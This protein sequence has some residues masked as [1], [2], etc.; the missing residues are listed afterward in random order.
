MILLSTFGCSNSQTHISS[1]VTPVNTTISNVLEKTNTSSSIPVVENDYD[2]LS[3]TEKERYD[4]IDEA[5]KNNTIYTIYFG[6]KDTIT[7]QIKYDFNYDGKIEVLHYTTTKGKDSIGYSI[8]KKCNLSMLGD[9][10]EQESFENHIGEG[11]ISLGIADFDKNDDCIDIIIKDGDI[12]CTSY[13]YR[14]ENNKFIKRAEITGEILATSGDGKVFFWGGNLY[15][16]RINEDFNTDLV[17]TYYDIV[18]NEYVKTYQ[19]IGKTIIS[20]REIIVFK[21]ADDVF[22]GPPITKDEILKMSEGK[23]VSILKANDKFEVLIIDNVVKI[24]TEDG[25]EGWIGGFHM[26]WD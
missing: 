20:D 5:I 8:I 13:V 3:A 16:P 4:A 26:I 2:K 9:S 24:R 19:L 1:D 6:N 12:Y 18:I 25:K 21:S 10:I 23:I 7:E 22:N 15:E 11:L 14:F 17:I